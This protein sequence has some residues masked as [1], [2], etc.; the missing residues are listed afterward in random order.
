[1]IGEDE[2]VRKRQL[3]ASDAKVEPNQESDY[4]DRSDGSDCKFE[5]VCSTSNLVTSEG[6]ATSMEQALSGLSA[7]WRNWVIRGVFSFFMLLA[8]SFVIY[9]GPLA[10]ITIVLLIQIKC[11][12]EIISIGYA[13]YRMHKLPWF[14]SLSWYFLIASDYFFYGEAVIDYFGLFLKRD[15]AWTHVTLLLIVAQSYLIIQNIFEGTI[16][17]IVPVLLIICNDM[18]AYLFGFFFGRTPL[19]KLSPKK[20]WEGFLGGA[21]STIIFSLLLSYVLLQFP[22]LVC[23]ATYNELKETFTTD[24]Q[25]AAT[26]KLQNYSIPIAPAF[27][28]FLLPRSINFR[29]YPFMFHSLTMALFASLIGPFGGF[30]ASGFKRAFKI[31]DFGAVIPGHGGL[32]DRFDCQLLMGTFVH[33]FIH[34]YVRV[35][36]PTKVVQRIMMLNNDVQI[37]VFML[38]YQRLSAAGLLGNFTLTA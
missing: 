25:V 36:D 34:T 24:C 3:N 10:L 2:N 37:E 22:Q 23:P 26:F 29:A 32:M 35:S 6:G 5:D 7:R 17:F 38:L 20:T 8:F 14:R 33:V 4:D 9:L 16:W 12:Q 27:L 1:M 28:H 11:F 31:K 21:F 15:F 13:I 18:T 19:I 30:F